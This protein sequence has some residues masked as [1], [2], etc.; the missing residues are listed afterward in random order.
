METTPPLPP[1]G[2]TLAP[3]SH[4]LQCPNCATMMLFLGCT[5]SEQCAEWVC[6]A[7]RV[8]KICPM[9]DLRTFP[10]APPRV[11]SAVPDLDSR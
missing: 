7:C 3:A 6:P 8:I 2:L 5:P 4:P 11:G 10:D 9:K 1:L